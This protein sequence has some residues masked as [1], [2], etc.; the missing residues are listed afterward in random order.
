[1]APKKL[2]ITCVHKTIHKKI[3]VSE[4]VSRGSTQAYIMQ[5]HALENLGLGI[6]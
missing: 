1:M 4:I 6:R 3:L 5:Y 2:C